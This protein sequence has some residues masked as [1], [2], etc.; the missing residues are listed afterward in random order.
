MVLFAL[1]IVGMA[2][3]TFEGY[4]NGETMRILYIS[5][6]IYDIYIY[7]SEKGGFAPNILN[8]VETH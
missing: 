2:L 4:V 6:T 1:I 3:F 5:P 7:I 8:L